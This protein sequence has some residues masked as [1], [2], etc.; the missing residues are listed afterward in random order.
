MV[1][2]ILSTNGSGTYR[3]VLYR[4]IIPQ[5]MIVGYVKRTKG[6]KFALNIGIVEFSLLQQPCSYSPINNRFGVQDK[7]IA[8]LIRQ[9]I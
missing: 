9:G 2:G 1:I 8:N 3:D 7:K 5:S 4:N 6:I